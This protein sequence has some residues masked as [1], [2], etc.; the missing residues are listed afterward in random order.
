MNEENVPNSNEMTRI[1]MDD[2]SKQFL[3]I[4]HSTC[5]ENRRFIIMLIFYSFISIS[6]GVISPPV[7]IM[8]QYTENLTAGSKVLPYIHS[9]VSIQNIPPDYY[10]LNVDWKIK[11]TKSADSMSRNFAGIAKIVFM[12]NDDTVLIL[13]KQQIEAELEYDED[14]DSSEPIH[15]FHS[16]V[17]EYNRINIELEFD[18]H[19][20]N[21]NAVIFVATVFRNEIFNYQLVLRVISSFF[22]FVIFCSFIILTGLSQK[23]KW[24][25]EQYCTAFLLILSVYFSNP[26]SIASGV[27]ESS[28][29]VGICC[30]ALFFNAYRA[31]ILFYF[32]KLCSNK[33]ECGVFYSIYL[34]MFTI[35]FF[36][37]EVMQGLSQTTL[38]FSAN[39]IALLPTETS[40]L[41]Y[42]YVMFHF[43][44]IF[45]LI[46]FVLIYHA[47]FKDT[48][49]Y[50][51][52]VIYC[53]IS[54]IPEII[55]IIVLVFVELF[56][57]KKKTIIWTVILVTSYQMALYAQSHFHLSKESF[58]KYQYSQPIDDDDEGSSPSPS[59]QRKRRHHRHK[60]HKHHSHPH[61]DEKASFESD[62]NQ[63]GADEV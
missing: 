21:F 18:S 13:P 5:L 43:F 26:I 46:I 23:E 53:C 34:F 56:D 29:I 20:I 11:R 33:V 17:K 6:L 25:A 51:R 45:S 28:R 35:S 24:V 7:Y 15:L 1:P 59:L 19:D 9:K 3:M 31:I 42:I 40:I 27:N 61:H 58:K 49:N 4:D 50:F 54:F 22:S 63:I 12:Q 60:N 52:F 48:L 37:V 10:F 30:Q 38:L 16:V 55:T 2:C 41:F 57:T 44:Y 32:K 47:H 8:N 39:R 36:V 62:D 14:S